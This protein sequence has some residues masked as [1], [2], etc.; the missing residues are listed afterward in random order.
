MRIRRQNVVIFLL[1]GT[2]FFAGCVAS[3]RYI[4][5]KAVKGSEGEFTFKEQVGLASYYADEFHGHPTASGEIFDMNGLTAAHRTLPLGTR[6]RVTNLE[7][8]KEVIVTVNDRGPYVK[9]R[10]LDLSKGAAEKI[11]MLTSG[12]A[13]VRIELVK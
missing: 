10:I 5:R 7:N 8:G 3:P 13:I 9:G 12:T 1:V 4:S 2:L 11:D 6:I